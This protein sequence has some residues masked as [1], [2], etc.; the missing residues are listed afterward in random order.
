MAKFFEG[1]II[2][3]QS[4]G[5]L[6]AQQF[7][8]V[9]QSTAADAVK[10]VTAATDRILGVLVNTPSTGGGDGASVQINGVAKVVQDSTSNAAIRRNDLVKAST[11]GGVLRSTGSAVTTYV[12]GI[13]LSA[14]SSGTTGYVT[15]FLSHLGYSSTVA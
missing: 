9:K 3:L 2:S 8:F 14:I 7:R 13:A 5:N 6:N 10:L 1:Q 12:P 15:V 11:L 4:S